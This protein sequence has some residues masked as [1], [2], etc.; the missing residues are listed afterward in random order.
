MFKFLTNLVTMSSMKRKRNA[1]TIETTRETIDQ[2][3]IEV[4]ASF[5]VVHYNN[6]IV[7]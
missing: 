6:G 7:V 4:R 3:A 1:V 2:L 5:L